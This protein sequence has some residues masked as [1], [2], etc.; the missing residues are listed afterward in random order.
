MWWFL[1]VIAVVAVYG[2]VLFGHH[3]YQRRHP[4][5]DAPVNVYLRHDTGITIPVDLLYRGRWGGVHHWWAVSSVML[6]LSGEVTVHA[7]YLPAHTQLHGA[8]RAP[9]AATVRIVDPP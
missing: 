4:P 2:G 9:A 6:P 1:A 5:E 3:R 7:D 8:V